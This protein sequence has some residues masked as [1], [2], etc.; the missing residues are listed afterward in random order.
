MLDGIEVCPCVYCGNHCQ[1]VEVDEDELP[2]VS[3]NPFDLTNP[4]FRLW[5]GCDAILLGEK[6]DHRTE[7]TTDFG[8]ALREWNDL[9]Q[10]K[11]KINV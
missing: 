3:S 9:N 4:T 2:F 1:T 6:D 5:R 7:W 10:E 11:H 8:E